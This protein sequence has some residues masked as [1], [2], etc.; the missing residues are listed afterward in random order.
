MV[1][2]QNRREASHCKDPPKAYRRGPVRLVSLSPDEGHPQKA[3]ERICGARRGAAA[4]HVPALGSL[5]VL[6]RLRLGRRLAPKLPLCSDPF[7]PGNQKDGGKNLISR[8]VIVFIPFFLT[9]GTHVSRKMAVCLKL[10]VEM[11]VP[12]V[13]FLKGLFS[14]LK[15]G[16][17]TVPPSP[18]DFLAKWSVSHKKPSTSLCP[19]CYTGKEPSFVAPSTNPLPAT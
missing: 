15:F 19:E 8:L 14:P 9:L 13:T 1:C 7:Q 3:D 6:G 2:K 17:M 4:D 18:A 16:K 12:F 10:F 11:T 5:D